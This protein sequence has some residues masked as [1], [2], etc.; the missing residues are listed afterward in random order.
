MAGSAWSIICDPSRVMWVMPSID[1]S[2]NFSK[3]RWMTL[4]RASKPI[5][6]IIPKGSGRHNFNLL[7]QMLGGA[8]IDFTGSNSPAN[9][10]SFPCRRVYQDE[11]E[12]FSTKDT[13]EANAS[14]LAD[15]RTKNQPNP[16]RVKTSTPG[17]KEGLIWQALEKTDIRR[18]F[19]PC[20]FCQ[21]KGVFAWGKKYTVFKITGNEFFVRWDSEA[22]RKDG[23]WDLDRVE[24]SAAYIC[25]HCQGRITDSYKTVMDRNGVW[26]PTKEAAHGFRGYHFPSMYA[27]SVET[28]VGKMAVKFLQ[29]THSLSGAQGFING[30]LAEPYLAQDTLHQRKEMVQQRIE[31]SD[32]WKPM[33]TVDCQAGTPAFWFAKGVF[34]DDAAQIIEAGSCEQ[35]EELRLIQLA[36]EP[37]IPDV[38]VG[39]DSGYGARSEAEVY[40]NCVR[41]G[42]LKDKSLTCQTSQG[43]VN[44]IGAPILFQGWIPCQSMPGRKLW[45]NG[46]SGLSDPFT[47]RSIDPFLGTQEAGKVDMP[48]FQF[49]ADFFED[50]LDNMR[51]GMAGFKFSVS[52]NVDKGILTH[53]LY[54]MTSHIAIASSEEFWQH[55]D[56]H[57][58]AVIQNKFSGATRHGWVKRHS[59]WPDHILDCVRNMVAL[60]N[61]FGFFSITNTKRE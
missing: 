32:T 3:T 1:N 17:V 34:R 47:I 23:T 31:I 33:M 54:P 57:F 14:D 37:K 48:L 16:F 20:P 50:I 59:H 56:G 15:Q 21:K 25:P 51:R 27:S 8:I 28:M 22:K 5:A 10:A 41:F 26:I 52:D 40:K 4:L 42:E 36:S 49:A 19:V 18:Y 11:M 55:M 44:R 60:A 6:D 53:N 30:D 61:F 9:L 46:E 29:Q 7:Q 2:R 45:K 24:R 35:W 43:L 58:K 39:V 38:L 12:K 13:G